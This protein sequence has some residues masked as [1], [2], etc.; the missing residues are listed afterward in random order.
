MKNNSTQIIVLAAGKGRRIKSKTLPKVMIKINERPI[1]NYVMEQVQLANIS[2]PIIVIGYKGE[3]IKKEFKNTAE[4]VWQ[5]DQLGTGHA[6]SVCENFIAQKAKNILVL[7]GDMPCVRAK[8]IIDLNEKHNENNNLPITMITAEVDDF[9]NWRQGFHGFGRILRN[10]NNEIAGIREM[11]DSLP[12]ELKIK[13][14]NPS[15][16]CFDRNWLFENLKKL[17]KNN[18]QGEY[19]L[20]DLIE[21]AFEQGHKIDNIKVDPIEC[22]GVNTLEQRKLVEQIIKNKK[23]YESDC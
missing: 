15:I 3:M 23:I 16:F 22:L 18:A 17:N 8:T 12:K 21:I 20:T 9:G 2:E 6:V 1:L 4:F 14:V 7:Y 10:K 19:Y 13:E 5:K 11:K